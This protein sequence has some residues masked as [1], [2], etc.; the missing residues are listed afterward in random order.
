[1][2]WLYGGNQLGA[3]PVSCAEQQAKLAKWTLLSTPEGGRSK[4]HQKEA[5]AALPRLQNELN[6]CL[7]QQQTDRIEQA[8]SIQQQ[9]QYGAP[10]IVGGGGI[11][12]GNNQWMLWV[13]LGVA[14]I[15]ATAWFL[16]KRRKR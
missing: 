8:A 1:M 15:V 9:I 7:A 13:G 16:S 4:E 6:T 10:P 2:N 12:G 3:E 11:A 5:K 14:G